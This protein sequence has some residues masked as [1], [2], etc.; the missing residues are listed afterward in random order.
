MRTASNGWKCHPKVVDNA[1]FTQ[2]LR[3]YRVPP[4]SGV[5]LHEPLASERQFT[6]YS[7]F[8]VLFRASSFWYRFWGSAS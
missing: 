4:T 3:L 7:E 2:F 6:I 8:M 1:P 5:L